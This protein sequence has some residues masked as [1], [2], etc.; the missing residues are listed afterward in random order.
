MPGAGLQRRDQERTGGARDGGEVQATRGDGVV[1]EE[2]GNTA[3][4]SM[5]GEKSSGVGGKTT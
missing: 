1:P 3:P 5:V 2:Q 4:A